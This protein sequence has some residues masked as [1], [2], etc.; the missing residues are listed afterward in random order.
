M[1]AVLLAG[2]CTVDLI[3]RVP[4]LPDAGE[5]SQSSAVEMAAG[6]PASNAAVT[7]AALGG[8]ARLLTA[9]G[10]HPLAI[11]ARDDLTAH[12]VELVD[13]TPERV[14]P[15]PVSAVA[16]RES[17]GERVVISHNA[18]GIDLDEPAPEL[19]EAR[20]VLVDG[21]HPELAL[22][23]AGAARA[24]GIPVIVDAGSWRPVFEELLPLVDV[25]ACSASFAGETDGVPVVLRTSGARPVRW[26][27]GGRKG[28]VPVPVVPVRDTLGAGDVWHGALAFAIAKLGRVPGAGEL[29]A[30][31]VEANRVASI[32][33][34]HSGARS[35]FT[36]VR[37]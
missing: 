10:T 11:L 15:P 14:D 33:V 31:L 5:K 20:A 23:V 35:W 30:V 21:H 4:E 2:L 6:G 17:D 3:Q 26:W 12:G 36:E 7:V 9:L 18:A 19:G 28:E 13:F 24:R 22:A 8:E 34:G 27:A 1:T 32:R 16:V 29:P 25:C 37:E